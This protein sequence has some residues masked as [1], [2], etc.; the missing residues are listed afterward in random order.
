MF[1]G[2]KIILHVPNK[3]RKAM[4]DRNHSFHL[5][6][7]KCKIRARETLFWP[8]MTSSIQQVVENCPVCAI[9]NKNRLWKWKHH[10]VHSPSY[11]LICLICK[12]I[13]TCSVLITSPN[14]LKFPNWKIKLVTTQ[15]FTWIESSHAMGYQTN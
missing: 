9:H 14:G 3:L 2:H 4:L 1:K 11:Q 12:D 5:G 6:M 15:S 7:V 10:Q 8:G 13:H